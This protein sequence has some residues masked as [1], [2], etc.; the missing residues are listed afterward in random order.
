LDPK[1]APGLA[2]KPSTSPQCSLVPAAFSCWSAPIEIALRINL[3]L[4]ISSYF[5]ATAPPEI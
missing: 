4:L 1:F 5:F 2:L 3:L